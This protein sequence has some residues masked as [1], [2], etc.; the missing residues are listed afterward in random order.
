MNS[1]STNVD[2][3]TITDKQL[4]II[5]LLLCPMPNVRAL[6]FVARRFN[7]C[8]DDRIVI[9]LYTAQRQITRLP[10]LV[11]RLTG[12]QAIDYTVFFNQLKIPKYSF[13]LVQQ[14]IISAYRC[15]RSAFH[16]LY[17]RGLVF[18]S[19]SRNTTLR[20]TNILVSKMQGDI[21]NTIAVLHYNCQN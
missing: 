21:K 9:K 18:S 10:L 17:K 5:L 3:K 4:Q 19:C 2:K 12:K 11:K 20:I 8:G 15:Q 16:L 14:M 6:S 1:V 7:V 13:E